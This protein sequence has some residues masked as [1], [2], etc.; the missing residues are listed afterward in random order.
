M[1][2]Q[3][4]IITCGGTGGH[5][6]PGLSL[7]RTFA[8][9]G[10]SVL[11]LLSGIHA[12][13]QK[14]IA[15]KNGIR[16][17]TLPEMPSPG[18]RHPLRAFRFLR[19]LF[20]GTLQARREI[21]AFRPDALLGM[22]SFASL[23]AIFAARLLRCPIFLHDGNARIGKANR[24]LSRQA[25]FLGTAF[26]AVNANR[27]RCPVACTGLPLRPELLQTPLAAA[28]ARRA[29]ADRFGIPLEPNRTTIL[30]FGGSQGAQALNQR[31]PE[32][33]FLLRDI[34]FQVLHLS[35]PGKFDDA[36]AVYA[37]APFP[38]L[39]LPATEEMALFYAAAD[40]V[41][42][43]SGGST[44]AELAQF[45]KPTLLIPYP[46][47]AEDHQTDNAR[48]FAAAGAVIPNARCTADH[49]T[50]LLRE[51]LQSPEKRDRCA[52]AAAALARPDA[53]DA[54]LQAIEQH[55]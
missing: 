53:S 25:R 5:F 55:I 14:A 3:R 11:L 9:R 26:P 7:A 49:L 2:L 50:A 18:F 44:V 21:R 8:E 39:V 54:L 17:L 37:N 52:S 4:L 20:G 41:V 45:G 35:G 34:P 15:E 33:L 10:G 32:A 12:A 51:F 23:P 22:G 29:L 24:F 16:A 6:Y 19:G 27:C 46:Y 48:H 38:A 1:K 13:R 28:E 36:K 43:R 47:A 40:L 30:I 42:S 31:V